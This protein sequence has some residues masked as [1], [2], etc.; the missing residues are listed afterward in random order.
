MK[1][2]RILS[3]SHFT[4]TI[5]CCNPTVNLN[6]PDEGPVKSVQVGD[7]MEAGLIQQGMDIEIKFIDGNTLYFYAS[8]QKL[9]SDLED[10]GYNIQ[11]TNPMQISFK[12]VKLVSKNNSKLSEE[13]NEIIQKQLQE[14]NIKVLKREKNYW[15]IYGSLENLSRIREL[16][17]KIKELDTEVRPRSIEIK[18]PTREDIQK[19]NEMNIDIYSTLPQKED[20]IIIYGGAYDYQIDLLESSGYEVKKQN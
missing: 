19:V 3:L 17:Y 6:P 8:N 13:K 5:M 16:G 9:I 2:L 1:F 10:I 15:A 14:Y 4:F 7:A 18:V 11:D 20:Y 12:L